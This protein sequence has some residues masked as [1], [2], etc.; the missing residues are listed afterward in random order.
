MRRKFYTHGGLYTQIGF[1]SAE[2]GMP[3]H[4]VQLDDMLNTSVYWPPSEDPGLGQEGVLDLWHLIYRYR[5]FRG[6]PRG[7][8][9]KGA[10][11]PQA[12]LLPPVSLFSLPLTCIISSAVTSKKSSITQRTYKL[13]TEYMEDIYP[14]T[15]WH[16]SRLSYFMYVGVCQPRLHSYLDTKFEANMQPS[17]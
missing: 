13:S 10:S 3:L 16:G 9:V 12:F 7:T 4:C 5:S 15:S 6:L 11:I 2:L 8:R 14:C 17:H 1:R